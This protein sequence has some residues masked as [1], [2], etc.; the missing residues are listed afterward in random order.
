MRPLQRERDRSQ[1]DLQQTQQ[2]ITAL[3]QQQQQ[4]L[5]QL[6]P[7]TQAVEQATAA[8]QQ[9]QLNQH[10]QETLIEQRIVP[11][12]NLIT[13]QQQTLSQLA[14]QIQ[15]LRAKEQQNSQQLALNEQKLLQTHQRLQQLADYANLHAH[16]QHWENIFPYGMSSSANYNYSNN[17]QLKVSNNYTNKQPYSPRCNSRLQH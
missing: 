13:Q 6:T 11:L 2:R 8:R 5:A 9:Q 4:Y 14:G 1:K 7:L 3:A 10:E 12:D 17:N 16:H 15:Q